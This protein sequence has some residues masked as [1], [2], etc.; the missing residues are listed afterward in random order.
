M[1]KNKTNLK[2]SESEIEYF[3]NKISKL[4][5]SKGIIIQFSVHLSP[6]I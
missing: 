2:N 4:T 5:N 3:C 1:N 6:M